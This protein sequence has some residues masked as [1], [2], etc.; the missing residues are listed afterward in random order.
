MMLKERRRPAVVGGRRRRPNHGEKLDAMS[1][2][3]NE[4]PRRRLMLILLA[5]L[6]VAAL[7][8]AGCGG[9]DDGGG[10]AG[11]GSSSADVAEA[12]RLAKQL[13]TRPTK[14][15]QT[16]PIDK[17][18]PT[19]KKITFIGCGPASCLVY[20]E[21]LKE[22][23]QMLGWTV[24]TIG[25]DGSP[26]RLQNA[27]KSAVRG[28]ADAI[29][30]PAADASALGASIADARKAG[31]VFVACCS[32]AKAPPLKG[33]EK[34]DEVDYNVST[35]QQ[36]G[37]IGDALAAKVVA[38]SKGEANSVYV[39]ISAFEILADVGKRFESKY[40]ELCPDCELDTLEVPLT[41]IGKDVPDRIVSYLRSHPDVNYVV[42]S[43]SGALYPGLKGALQAAG[44]GDKVKIIGRGGGDASVY[45]AVE[46]GDITALVPPEHY[47]VDYSVLDFL[48]RK[49]AG[50]P[51]E[52]AAE[53][54]IWLT[55]PDTIPSTN[56]A[57]FPTVENYKEQWAELWGKSA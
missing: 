14:I 16:E 53:P 56:E 27:I 24:E 34:G 13:E 25:T 41:A 23:A 50:V 15:N 26:E 49:W 28:D 18:I 54:N 31:V 40:T 19:G 11:G 2:E 30:L 37:A 21:I 1:G 42:L 46:A 10:G 43:E 17:P 9:D 57:V 7:V 48:A 20:G 35:P 44:L 8:A 4:A 51:V 3:R 52:N 33:A 55:T 32:L 36:N 5:A 45:Q 12:E 38:D 47:S 39:N 29:F 6:A 22:G